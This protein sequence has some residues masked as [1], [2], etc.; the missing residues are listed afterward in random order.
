M[1][2]GARQF[3]RIDLRVRAKSNPAL[4][5]A[6]LSLMLSVQ[7]AVPAQPPQ[8]DRN[9]GP[10]LT[11]NQQTR[12]WNDYV[13]SDDRHRAAIATESG[14]TQIFDIPRQGTIA[15]IPAVGPTV[16]SPDGSSVV[17]GGVDGTLYLWTA[18]RSV[19]AMKECRGMRV[20]AIAV[21]RDW[22]RAFWATTDGHIR[23]CD[24]STQQAV[25]THSLKDS[26]WS[27]SVS[28][29]GDSVL[30]TFG[31]GAL[32]SGRPSGGSLILDGNTG[33]RRRNLDELR[34]PAIIAGALSADG[35]RAFTARDGERRITAW[36]VSTGKRIGPLLKETGI[37]AM[38]LSE[39]SD[40]LVVFDD[41]EKLHAVET[42]NG[43]IRFSID[44]PPETSLS[45]PRLQLLDRGN[46]I[47]VSSQFGPPILLSASTGARIPAT[48]NRLAAPVPLT[49]VSLSS[50]GDLLAGSSR[51]FV[52]IWNVTQGKRVFAVGNGRSAPD[53]LDILRAA[54]SYFYADCPPLLAGNTIADQTVLMRSCGERLVLIDLG[55]QKKTVIDG[56]PG[57]DEQR[58]KVTWHGVEFASLAESGRYVV[59]NIEH[60]LTEREL[61]VWRA[62]FEGAPFIRLPLEDRMILRAGFFDQD[63]QLW[64]LTIQHPFQLPKSGQ[65]EPEVMV[66]NLPDG[67]VARRQILPCGILGEEND[68]CSTQQIH[69][70]AKARYV[71]FNDAEGQ[72]GLLE[73]GKP[74]PPFDLHQDP[75]EGIMLSPSVSCDE[76]HVLFGNTG[77]GLIVYDLAKRAPLWTIP[78]ESVFEGESLYGGMKSY[79]MP[80]TGGIY[81]A[82]AGRLVR[83]DEKDPAAT[84][85]WFDTQPAEITSFAIAPQG[86]VLYAGTESGIRAFDARTGKPRATLLALNNG[87]SV[88]TSRSG[89]FETSMFE[90]VR[91]MNWVMPD[92]PARPLP[93]E[94]FMRDYFEPR[95]LPKLLKNGEDS[96]PQLPPVARLNRVQPKVRI[97]GVR[98]GNSASEVLVD[99]V[100]SGNIDPLA[101]N[102][103]NAT[104][105]YDLRLF[106][107]GQLVGQ[108][109]DPRASANLETWRKHS[110]VVLPSGQ[111]SLPP[112][113][114]QL[115]S[116]S[117]G[118]PVRFSAYAFNED[119]VKSETVFDE[120]YSAPKEI[121]VRNPRA[122][123]VAVGVNT[124]QNPGRNLDFA[125][126]DARA[127]ARS[128]TQIENHDVVTVPLI[129]AVGTDGGASTDHATKEI[130]RDVLGLLS[131]SPTVDRV[132]LRR[133]LGDV[134]DRLVPAT[135]DDLVI[136][137]FAGH[138]YTDD[139]SRFFLVP[140]NSGSEERISQSPPAKLISTDDLTAWLRNVDAE[141]TVMIIDACYAADV[142]TDGKRE[143]KPGPMGD[144]GLGQLAYDKGMRIL[145][146][147]QATDFALES[148]TIDAG[149]L[150]YAL[151]DEG[152]DKRL[153]DLDGN[154]QL[155][156][157]EWLRYGAKRVPSLY[158]EILDGKHVA[159]A[160]G[161]KLDAKTLRVGEPT[162]QTPELFDFHT[163][164][165]RI[166]LSQGLARTN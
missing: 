95:L 57:G 38:V 52:S 15:A 40:L 37:A 92:D 80:C 5:L 137:A 7:S 139:A 94:M 104:E 8:A 147:T 154:G 138:G 66:L 149:M 143:L 140:A 117:A 127:L 30:V 132:A 53:G 146:A 88:V 19:I 22:R 46:V 27:L 79:E 153:A 61:L 50:S 93:L 74:G 91:G 144:R 163:A 99:L 98:R 36:N 126:N 2:S 110:Q 48:E 107:N 12:S 116:R 14:S 87:A 97:A 162:A 135:P 17:V 72:P 134:V 129:S 25:W 76:R 68:L 43:K 4:T 100:A 9:D 103:K 101:R 102:G 133:R 49:G 112:F 67:T 128:L 125:A 158:R 114:V 84:P 121:P 64:V 62:P 60:N 115:A 39:Q 58:Y 63:R 96:L 106:R 89:R 122:W 118:K 16:V 82:A 131:G 108:W 151:V 55:T 83:L 28:A 13:L 31:V 105:A 44:A 65:R 34:G 157:S 75:G 156:L 47:A 142:T 165:D 70:S 155:T 11:I 166:V 10:V 29:S 161:V 124:H 109:P 21:T 164:D 59:A 1:T 24:L 71:G 119:R 45:S 56:G 145:A 18:D 20:A 41:W 69:V 113:R 90:D 42:Q 123:V 54:D 111:T 148:S 159:R 33:V 51:K 160:R 150:T 85:I 152:L 136:F 86:N 81:I 35:T 141:Q 3:V 6:T 23:A 78:L 130:I 32:G 73:I 26:V 120:S 77:A